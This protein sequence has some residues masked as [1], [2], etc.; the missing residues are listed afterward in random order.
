MCRDFVRRILKKILIEKKD[1]KIK[2]KKDFEEWKENTS[3]G[4]WA[5]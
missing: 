5:R 2:F 4:T 3:Q 1:K